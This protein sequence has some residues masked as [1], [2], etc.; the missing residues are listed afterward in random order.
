MKNIYVASS[1]RNPHQPEVVKLLRARGFT[2]YDFKNPCLGNHGFNW[3]EI[4]PGWNAGGPVDPREL[5]EG[6]EHPTAVYGYELDMNALRASDTCL[7]VLPSGRSSHY[8]FGW[9][10]GQGKECI[11]YAPEP[12]EPELMIR[13]ARILIN[14]AELMLRFMGGP[15]E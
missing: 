5:R 2:V 9:A 1:W 15:D 7:L 13:E 3:K 10:A 8:E 11:V 14:W 12:I 4:N 6:L